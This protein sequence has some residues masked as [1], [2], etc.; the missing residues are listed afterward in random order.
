MW[1]KIKTRL[2]AWFTGM[3]TS[4]IWAWLLVLLAAFW[5]AVGRSLALA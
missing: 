5:L 4:E 3:S 1:N 2:G